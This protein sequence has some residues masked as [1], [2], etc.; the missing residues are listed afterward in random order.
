MA[1]VR[2]ESAMMARACS[3]TA[4]IARPAIPIWF[5]PERSS[6]VR[7]AMLSLGCRTPGSRTSR[8]RIA[9]SCGSGCNACK[10]SKEVPADSLRR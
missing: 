9:G 1:V 5:T 10:D 8:Y 2:R 6:T 4:T 7:L 3:L